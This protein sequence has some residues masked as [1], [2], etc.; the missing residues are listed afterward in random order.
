MITIYGENSRQVS[1]ENDPKAVIND[2]KFWI[3]M[4][5]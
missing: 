1:V 3:C 4:K 5:M 2:N